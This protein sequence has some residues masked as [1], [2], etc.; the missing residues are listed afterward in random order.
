M[1]IHIILLITFIF[2]VYCFSDN[3]E[4]TWDIN[5]NFN[6]S[7]FIKKNVELN[8]INSQPVNYS[9]KKEKYS[10]NN[11]TDLY[12]SFDK[13]SDYD[14]TG[15]YKFI[16]KKYLPSKNKAV[17]DKSAYFIGDKERIELIGTE[18]SFF[19]SGTILG[20]FSISFWIYTPSFA[21]N[22]IVL[23]IGSEFYDK[24]LDIVEDQ[25]ILAK[26]KDGKLLWEFNNI[27]SANGI[28]IDSIKLESYSRIIPEKWTHINLVY[29]SHAGIIREY[30]DGEEDGIIITTVDKTLNSSVLNLKYHHSNRCVII[31]A[32]SF[33]GAIDEFCIIKKPEKINTNKYISN[34]GE[35]ISKV[36]DLGTGG[37]FISDINTSEFK[38]K[39]SEIIYYYR[40]SEKPFDESEEISSDI[41]WNKINLEDLSNINIRFFQWKV[42]LLAG[43]NRDYTPKFRGISIKYNPNYPPARP[44]GLKI[45]FDN[46]K[47]LL[48]WKLN[49]EKDL[50]GYKIYYGTKSNN[51]FGKDANQGESPIDVGLVNSYEITGLKKN[52]IY[53]FTISAY[54]DD[55]HIHESE[56]SD[57]VS[58][59]PL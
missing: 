2:N 17:Y 38:E 58:I 54:D 27:F 39:N 9:L 57:E 21:N 35:I 47:I 46:K 51:Y 18:K 56:F 6:N 42:I 1:R 36:V 25:S 24:N 31:I 53:Y 52:I 32:P 37:V 14:E 49:S 23:R 3:N 41:K 7:I 26:M 33:N 30:I 10:I 22:E 44:F 20:S 59:R 29:D 13:V 45:L 50:K 40:N 48:K 19:Q 55:E 4:K 15:N 8:Y 11:D 16:Y 34:T 12:L 28:K 43:D 5:N